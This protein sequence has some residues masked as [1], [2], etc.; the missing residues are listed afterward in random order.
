M[1]WHKHVLGGRGGSI[2]IVVLIES[3]NMH[4]QGIECNRSFRTGLT[5]I[6]GQM[7]ASFKKLT[8]KSIY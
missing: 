1:V 6:E 4:C 7:L 3:A 5:P 8:A 2:E